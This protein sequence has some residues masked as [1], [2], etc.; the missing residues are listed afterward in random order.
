MPGSRPRLQ[1]DPCAPRSRSGPAG[2][3]SSARPPWRRPA[4]SSASCWSTSACWRGPAARPG[5]PP[6]PAVAPALG[7]G[8]LVFLALA[9]GVTVRHRLSLA[10]AAAAGVAGLALAGALAALAHREIPALV[11]IGAAVIAAVPEARR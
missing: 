10:R 9:L 6:P 5:P 3:C 1:G 7:V 4:R 2:S 11:P 8:A